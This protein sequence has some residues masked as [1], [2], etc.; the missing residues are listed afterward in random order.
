[1]TV[2]IQINC[3]WDR[4]GICLVDPKKPGRLKGILHHPEFYPLVD[5]NFDISIKPKE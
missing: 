3:V 2:M 5:S 1:M 4:K